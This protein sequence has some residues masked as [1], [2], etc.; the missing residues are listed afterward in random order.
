[1]SSESIPIKEGAVA[2][3][4]KLTPNT[5]HYLR[6]LALKNRWVIAPDL[7]QRLAA[8]KSDIALAQPLQMAYKNKT[9]AK[10]PD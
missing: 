5:I 8:E 2:V 4:K 1:M 7:T 3:L 10:L 6:R 9:I